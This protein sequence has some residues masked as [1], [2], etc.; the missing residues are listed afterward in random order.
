MED[1]TS[2]PQL[3]LIDIFSSSSCWNLCLFVHVWKFV[4]TVCAASNGRRGS[5]TVK[6]Y[7]KNGCSDTPFPKLL[8]G[9]DNHFTVLQ[10]EGLL[11]GF[12]L[13]KMCIKHWHFCCHS[14][15]DSVMTQ[16]LEKS[17][18][19]Y[20]FHSF[21]FP[22]LTREWFALSCL[23]SSLPQPGSIAQFPCWVSQAKLL[24]FSLFFSF[25]FLFHIGQLPNLM[26]SSVS[27]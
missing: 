13:S 20:M 15:L 11:C 8:Q 24:F 16:A 6:K 17:C 4:P 14:Y 22:L 12:S 19:N 9:S 26:V 25:F 7:L 10:A 23:S 5:T 21:N 2:Q 1:N 27:L 3:I 18:W